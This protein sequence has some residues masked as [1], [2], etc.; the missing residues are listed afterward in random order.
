MGFH[1]LVRATKDLGDEPRARRQS[2]DNIGFRA[3]PA[4]LRQVLGSRA[5][6]LRPQLI[7]LYS[8]SRSTG[9]R[10]ATRM[11][12]RSSAVLNISGVRAPAMW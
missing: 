7:T 3:D 6:D 4:A 8:V 2:A 1:G 5:K 12:R 10:P 9:V 11:S